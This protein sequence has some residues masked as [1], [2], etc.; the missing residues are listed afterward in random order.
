[1]FYY[2]VLFIALYGEQIIVLQ[3]LPHMGELI[4]LCKKRLTVNLE[5]SLISCLALLKHIIPYLSDSTLMDQLHVSSLV[6]VNLY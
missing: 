6:I 3:Y 2:I 4:Q 5:G 1:M